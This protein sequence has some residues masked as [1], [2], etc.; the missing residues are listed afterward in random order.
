MLIAFRSGRYEFPYDPM[1]IIAMEARRDFPDRSSLFPSVLGLQR[2]IT[3]AVRQ[4]SDLSHLFGPT[5]HLLWYKRAPKFSNRIE[6][7]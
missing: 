5:L 1:S 3:D 7:S 2:T 4:L 6:V